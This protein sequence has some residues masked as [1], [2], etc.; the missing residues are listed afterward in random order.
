MVILD[1]AIVNV[2]LPSVQR[3]LGLTDTGLAW[4]VN[5]YGI[6]PAAENAQPA[7]EKTSQKCWY[8]LDVKLC[9]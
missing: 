8:V 9:D 5:G 3:D 7:S 6:S 4:V 2:A 1:A